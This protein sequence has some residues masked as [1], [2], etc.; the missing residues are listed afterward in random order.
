MIRNWFLGCFNL[1]I[2]ASLLIGSWPQAASAS[3]ESEMNLYYKDMS[4]AQINVTGPSA[5]TSQAA[6]YYSGGSVFARFPQKTVYPLNLQLP[7]ASGGCGGIDIFGGSFS[8]ADSDQ[9]IALAKS[10]INNAKGYVFKLAISA[11]SGLIGAKLDDIQNIVNEINSAN[12]NSCKAAQGLVNRAIDAIDLADTLGCESIRNGASFSSDWSKAMQ[13]CTDPA[14]RRQASDQAAT[15][16]D[17]SVKALSDWDTMKERNVTWKILMNSPEFK[18]R[19]PKF[20]ELMMTLLGTII[21]RKDPADSTKNTL[22]FKGADV[23]RIKQLML[24][25]GTDIPVLSCGGSHDPDGCLAVTSVNA[26]VD[27]N[28]SLRGLVRTDIQAIQTA[29]SNNQPLT[30]AQIQLLQN[31]SIPV[32]KMLVVLQ[33]KSG[34]YISSSDVDDM[35]DLVAIDMLDRMLTN[36]IQQLAGAEIKS[37]GST[38]V[39]IDQWRAQFRNVSEILYQDRQAIANRLAALQGL[40]QR[41]QLLESTLQNSLS[42]QM[43]AALGFARTLRKP[44]I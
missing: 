5:Y 8:F 43:N 20:N 30:A 1:V 6:G 36:L 26:N 28:K 41:S 10:I 44:G 14:K 32:Y 37:T 34:S 35:A 15:S 19:D 22:D 7:S 21:V 40:V 13:D 39:E 33:A 3:V 12:I 42:G 31:T 17:P 16:G 9:Y 23:G 29:I 38:T 4:A 11:L 2:I 18:D 25:G 27:P 24:D